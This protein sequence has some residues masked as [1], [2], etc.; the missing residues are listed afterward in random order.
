MT[1]KALAVVAALAL[2]ACSHNEPGIEVRTVE[3][4]KEVQKPC[5]GT[6][7]TRPTPLGPLAETTRAALAQVL[8]KLTEYAGEGQYADQAELY[9]ETCPPSTE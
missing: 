1:C 4:I 7:P 3:V 9:F 5:P 8:A 2:A 6:V